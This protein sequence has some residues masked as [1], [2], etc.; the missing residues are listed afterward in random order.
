MNLISGVKMGK[1]P[2]RR[3]QSLYCKYH[4]D[5]R[6]TTKQCRMFKDYQEQLV[7]VGHLREYV[8]G[9]GGTVE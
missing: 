6:H 7:K 8:V 4:Q 3:N 9:Q 5:N 2:V 1:N